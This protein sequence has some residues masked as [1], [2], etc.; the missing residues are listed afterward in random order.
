MCLALKNSLLINFLRY[1]NFFVKNN[2]NL[3]LHDKIIL[4]IFLFFFPLKKWE[5]GKKVKMVGYAK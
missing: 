3:L 1:Y 5:Q 4:D 2:H